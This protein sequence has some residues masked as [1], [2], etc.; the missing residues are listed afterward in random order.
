MLQYC[1]KDLCV[2]YQVHLLTHQEITVLGSQSTT[3]VR[4]HHAVFGKTS[5]ISSITG[6]ID[7]ASSYVYLCPVDFYDS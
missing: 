1:T 4:R 5:T 2:E 7:G 6:I 3:H